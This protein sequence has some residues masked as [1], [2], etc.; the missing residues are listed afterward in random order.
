MGLTAPAA[1]PSLDDDGNCQVD[2]CT[3][4]H[5]LVL[6]AQYLPHLNQPLLGSDLHD[7]LYEAAVL[8]GADDLFF[9]R[10]DDR[11]GNPGLHPRA[12]GLGLAAALLGELMLS[13][14][15][16]ITDGHLV[17]VNDQPPRDV[18]VHAVLDHVI[19]E[20]QPHAVRTWLA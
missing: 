19:A 7:A 14:R 9:V 2:G 3:T 8:L 6:A 11:T 20:Q 12:I 16:S 15:L 13:H 4:S 18:V 1:A 10:H 17:V 5:L